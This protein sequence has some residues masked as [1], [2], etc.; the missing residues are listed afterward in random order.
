MEK[1]KIRERDII[2]DDEDDENL[3]EEV[4]VTIVQEPVVRRRTR[5]SRAH[6]KKTRHGADDEGYADE[7]TP[8][9]Q[10]KPGKG[11]RQTPLLAPNPSF[12]PF[13]TLKKRA[14]QGKL[15]DNGW[16]T[17]DATDVQDMG[18]FDFE[19]NLS[20]F[21]KRT[22]FDSIRAE[23]MTADEDRLVGHNRLPR[24]GT[25]GGRNLH[26]TEN[27][28]DQIKESAQWNSE[29]GDSEMDLPVSSQRGSGSGRASRRGNSL[30]RKPTSLKNMKDSSL[31]AS[32]TRAGV[33]VSATGLRAERSRSQQ[34]AK[35]A[36]HFISSS[37]RCEVA[38]ALQMLNIE[39][40]AQSELGLSED[41]MTENAGRGLA[42]VTLGSLKEGRGRGK[43]PSLPY[44]VVYAGNNKSGQRAI[45]AARHL[46]NHGAS[47]VV[48]ML[49]LERE[50]ELL[51]G[52]RRQLKVFRAFS[53]KVISKAEMLEWVKT[54][55][56]EGD[57]RV[58]IIIDGLLGLALSFEELRTSEQ[59]AVFELIEWSNRSRAQVI[60]VDIPSGIDPA[61]GRVQIVDGAPLCVHASSVVA[62]GAPKTGLLKAMEGNEEPA[63]LKGR[64][65]VWRVWVVDL[66]LGRQAWK[67]S[68]MRVR[69]GVEFE[70]RW[71][72]EMRFVRGLE[73][74]D[75]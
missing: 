64:E 18:D 67:R 53:G 45:A 5:R 30:L 71:C 50:A 22:V 43:L 23:D 72:V 25:M 14:K 57:A 41:M 36:F 38:S 40:I 26:P 66:G 59:A 11:W 24:P 54:L 51:D 16:A 74:G 60:A 4:E 1:M 6:H 17:E 8:A 21:D 65:G 58:E 49:G 46:K 15:Y 44:V 55:S 56:G 12:Q 68:G 20:K 62:M 33:T 7:V 31:H 10:T 3:S 13:T 70:G 63:P 69:R 35:S 34:P 47:V 42:E 2:E 28:L 27:V 61:T 39:N 37:R 73:G 52:V 29:A 48:V 32:Q 9:S 19:S 75:A